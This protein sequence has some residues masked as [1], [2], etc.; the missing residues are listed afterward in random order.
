T[1]LKMA[2]MDG[3]Q[4]CER[5]VA[6]RP[7]IPVLVMTAFG[8]VETAVAAIRIGAY[9]FITK[10]IEVDALV[11]ALERA[12]EHRALRAE[13]EQLRRLV[14]EAGGYGDLIGESVAMQRLYAVLERVAP[15][16][17]TVLIGGESGT[18]KEIVARELHRRSTRRAG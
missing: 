5:L 11:V 17:A 2:D 10:P 3:L 4:L 6:L 16:D 7:E 8:S 18:G 15:T 1:D 13:V 12:L 14:D 9:D